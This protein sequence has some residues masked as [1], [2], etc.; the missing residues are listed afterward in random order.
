M[1]NRRSFLVS[2]AAYGGRLSLRH[3]R[4]RQNPVRHHRPPTR[5]SYVG[6]V[7]HRLPGRWNW[8]RCCD[9]LQAQHASSRRPSWR[10]D[11]QPPERVADY[12]R[13]LDRKGLDAL[14][15]TTPDPLAWAHGHRSQPGGQRRLL[16]R[17]P[18]T[19]SIE[20]WGRRCARR[21]AATKGHA[22][23]P[24]AALWDHFQENANELAGRP[25]RQSLH[26]ECIYPGQ[27]HAARRRADGAA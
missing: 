16:A 3:R 1:Q 14:L 6:G 26:V 20:W 23:R 4:E 9:V 18:L 5:G 12:R 25:D 21:P 7:F 13:V 10:E 2:A 11:Q 27:L 19:N 15:I 17:R 22:D 8:C 24:P